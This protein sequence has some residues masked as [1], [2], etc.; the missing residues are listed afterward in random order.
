LG[1]AQ[2]A[3]ALAEADITAI[4]LNSFH[5]IDNK[6]GHLLLFS[7]GQYIVGK[8]YNRSSRLFKAYCLNTQQ[9]KRSA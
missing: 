4:C 1:E 2:Q 7:Y 8:E 9:F 5:I 6:P 3:G